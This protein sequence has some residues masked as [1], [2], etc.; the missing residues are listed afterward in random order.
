MQA[1]CAQPEMCVRGAAYGWRPPGLGGH[2][3]PLP[4]GSSAA[5]SLLPKSPWLRMRLGWVRKARG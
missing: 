2:S 4:L 5:Q 3:I 1:V